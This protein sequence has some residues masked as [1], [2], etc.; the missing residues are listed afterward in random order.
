MVHISRP[1]YPGS[2]TINQLNRIMSTLP[3]PSRQDVESIK[4]PYAKA[5]L[6]QI[7]HN[8]MCYMSES[9]SVLSCDISVDDRF[10]V[11][12]S[13]DKKATVYEVIFDLQ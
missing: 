13:G 4:S 3:P 6:D 9:S 5:I 1:L 11:T 8:D 12:G 7:I 10:I 2:S